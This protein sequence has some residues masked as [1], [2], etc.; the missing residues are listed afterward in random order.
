MNTAEYLNRINYTGS[1]EPVLENLKKIQQAHLYSVP[2]ENLDIYH[3]KRIVLDTTYEKVVKKNRGGFCYEL[4]S[5]YYE[6]LKSLGFDV[7]L[8]SA[9]VH[10]SEKKEF[11]PEFDHMCI[12]ANFG[13]EKYITDVGFGDFVIHPLKIEYDNVQQDP[14][15]KFYV[16]KYKDNFFQVINLYK[17]EIVPQCIFSETER[18]VNDFT[19]M[20]NYHQTSRDS[21]FTQ[22][23]LC[24]MPFL[25]GRMTLRDN[26]FKLKEHG[27][28]NE[29]V[30]NSEDEINKILAEKFKI[31]L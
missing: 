26:K 22:M 23:R 12:I 6:L 4:N 2:F 24:T 29:T 20:C 13:G 11:G 17:D 18:S 30:L 25:N 27:V 10:D 28:V 15:G 5:I 14:G 16:E 19:E 1:T 8:I 3:G 21:H 31:K 7:R 9:R